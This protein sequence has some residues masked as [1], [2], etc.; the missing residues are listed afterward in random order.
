[1]RVMN[2]RPSSES[3]SVDARLNQLGHESLRS[4]GVYLA[5]LFAI[6]FVFNAVEFPAGLRAPILIHDTALIAV[7]LI[8]HFVYRRSER[9]PNPHLWLTVTA[10]LVVSNVV[11]ALHLRQ[12]ALYDNYVQLLLVVAG[13]FFLSLRHYAIFAVGAAAMWG[14]VAWGSELPPG[15]L[16]R[17]MLMLCTIIVAFLLVSVRVRWARRMEGLRLREE[18][19]REDLA[20][21]LE[22]A[23]EEIRERQRVERMLRTSEER[24]V[25]L[26][27]HLL[28]GVAIF[29]PLNGGEDF[30]FASINHALPELEPQRIVG[31][32]LAGTFP[33]IL[34]SQAGADLRLAARSG[35]ETK[36]RE[37]EVHWGGA[38][39]YLDYSTFRLPGGDVVAVFQDRSSELL[40]AKEREEIR[41]RLLAAQKLE[42]L[43]VMA[44]GIAHDFNNLLMGVLANADAAT[45]RIE[46]APFLRECL[47]DMKTAATRASGLCRQL[48]DYS[49]Q[50]QV[51]SK[52]LDANILL[53]ELDPLVE[54][55]V[56]GNAELEVQ[57]A[58]E[59]LTVTGDAERLK[60]VVINLVSNASEAKG[61]SISLRTRRQ[62]FSRLELSRA[63]LGQDLPA[64]DYCVIR[65]EDDGQGIPDTAQ[66][67]VFDPFFSTRFT[68][69]GLGLS[70][71]VGIV[72]AHR[73]AIFLES[74][75]GSGTRVTVA[76]PLRPR[77][78]AEREAP[79]AQPSDTSSPSRP[80]VLLVD[81]D[82]TTRR[83]VR[84]LLEL[85]SLTITEA[86]NGDEALE[87]AAEHPYDVILLDLT[88]PRRGGV[89]TFPDLA[90]TLPKARIVLMSGYD[91]SAD[92]VDSIVDHPSF[93][94]FLAKPYTLEMLREAV[95]GQVLEN[96]PR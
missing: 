30:L 72:R 53:R 41:D 40:A 27:E 54:A 57:L 35:E 69:R 26:F 18:E 37:V 7:G 8:T 21:A 11:H 66:A 24:F 2:P 94:G 39:R 59:A 95:S 44:G 56:T 48:L 89:E 33:A 60:Q 17:T 46:D 19:Q 43:G 77:V 5:I 50:T 14:A 82:P 38:T 81:D 96:A 52:D 42:S 86:S 29:E 28:D 90:A 1:M 55:A 3:R 31:K 61:T 13:A 6:Y 91:S 10:L 93:G 23:R 88:M 78:R 58:S 76:L 49:G 85:D 67:R 80:T 68:G 47:G 4:A 20:V 65:V 62:H 32:T 73:G 25:D 75:E 70:A 12:E 63:H 92:G 87:R 51:A 9:G 84:R 79:R 64:G 15:M 34:E 83:S 45:A 22:G 16:H 74:K 71:V 36:R